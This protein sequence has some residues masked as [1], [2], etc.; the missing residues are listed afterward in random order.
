MSSPQFIVSVSDDFTMAFS[1]ALSVVICTPDVFATVALTLAHLRVQTAHDQIELVL[2]APNRDSLAMPDGGLDGFAAVQ[3]V[4]CGAEQMVC[5][6]RALGV[7]AANGKSVIFAEDHCFPASD[8]AEKIIAAHES[9]YAAVGPRF[10]NANPRTSLSW[11]EYLLNFGE[12]SERSE[13]RE[14]A[15]LA[16][17]N[18]S[19][20]REVL[21]AYGERLGSMLAVEGLL[22]EDL[23]QQGHRFYLESDA[24]V[25]H[26]NTSRPLEFARGFFYSGWLFGASRSRSWTLPRRIFQILASPFVP[27]RRLPGQVEQLKRHREAGVIPPKVSRLWGPSLLVGSIL[28][29]FGETLGYFCGPGNSLRHKSN[30]E[31]HRT[32]HIARVDRQ[33]IRQREKDI[34]LKLS[35][36]GRTPVAPVAS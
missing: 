15:A 20:K 8:W 35:A 12:W 22:M 2:V 19:Y 23:K 21:V 28:H 26:L 10:Y 16:W 25:Y 17:H 30:L 5:E 3:I 9:S 14:V 4:E 33:D 13:S 27:F 7:R 6:M 1:P 18:T 34:A 24:H 32:R 31:S 36:E 11:Q 29:V